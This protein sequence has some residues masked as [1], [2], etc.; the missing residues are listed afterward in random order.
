MTMEMTETELL[1]AGPGLGEGLRRH[2]G[3]EKNLRI[4]FA[5]ALLRNILHSASQGLGIGA[6]ITY[7]EMLQMGAKAQGD[8]V[9]VAS[10]V[11]DMML[12]NAEAGRQWLG[13]M[14]N[15]LASFQKQYSCEPVSADALSREFRATLEENEKFRAIKGQRLLLDPTNYQG[16]VRINKEG[17]R[18]ILGE[19]LLNAFKYSPAGSQIR[20]IHCSTEKLVSFMVVN[21]VETMHGGITGLPAEYRKKIFEPFF[22][23]NN[24][25][26]DRF[27]NQRF[28]LGI[29]LTLAE[30]VANQCGGRLY[31]Y[32]IDLASAE[33]AAPAKGRRIV[34]ELVLE[35][36]AGT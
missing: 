35:K 2:E 30:S 16:K 31:S 9:S 20:I 13:A 26:D 14:E 12:T 6:V 4:H 11:F 33:G 32:E 23:L 19:L 29:G 36:V 3:H 25:W 17:F 10:D 34:S 24:T 15:I 21:E 7:A 5:E 1:S 28:G 22:R 18:E 8:R 27:N